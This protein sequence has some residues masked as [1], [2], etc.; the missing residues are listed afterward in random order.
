MSDLSTSAQ[1]AIHIRTQIFGVQT[2]DAFAEM[3]GKAQA[4]VSRYETGEIQLNR[5][6]QAAIRS[7]AK[8]RGIK[9][10]DEWF[11]EVPKASKRD[12]RAA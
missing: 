7:L 9:W 5:D 10:R 4:T 11:F 8:S 3:L 6:V 12:R 1:C 2:Q